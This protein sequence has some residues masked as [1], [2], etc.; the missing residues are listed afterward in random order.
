MPNGW[1]SSVP[2][3]SDPFW[4]QYDDPTSI[5]YAKQVVS[6]GPDG[7]KAFVVE[8]YT[9]AIFYQQSNKNKTI[10]YREYGKNEFPGKYPEAGKNYDEGNGLKMKMISVGKDGRLWGTNNISVGNKS[11][12]VTYYKDTNWGLQDWVRDTSSRCNKVSATEDGRVCCIGDDKRIYVSDKFRVWSKL[13]GK[14]PRD[15]SD[16]ES[17]SCASGG[18]LCAIDGQ[19]NVYCDLVA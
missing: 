14:E 18:M 9:G 4:F 7:D 13:E 5:P 3:A 15:W 11:E 2:D 1:S 19:K 10:W 17:V 6:Q 8:M 12:S 16:I